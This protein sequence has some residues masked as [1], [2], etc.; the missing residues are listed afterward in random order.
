MVAGGADLTADLGPATFDLKLGLALALAGLLA[1]LRLIFQLVVAWL[2]ARISA[3]VQ[4]RLRRDVFGAFANASW[5]TQSEDREGQLQELMTSQI[6]QATNAVLSVANLLSGAAM[7]LVLLVSA[8]LLSVQ[9]A[10]AV[11]MSAVAMLFLLRPL[12]S[13]GRMAAERLSQASV[14]HAVGVNEAVQ[15]AE[16]AHVFG[17]AAEH[18]QRVG[19]LIETARGPFF[20]FQLSGRVSQSAYQGLIIL[21]IVG[22]LS[23]LYLTGRGNLPTLGAA[24]L[25]LVRAAT[26]GQQ[27]QASY[28]GLNQMQPYLDRL[29]SAVTR[30]RLSTPTEGSLSLPAIRTIAMREVAFSYRLDQPVLRIVSFEVAAGEA[31]GVVGPSGAGK[32]TLVQLLL[33]LRDPTSGTLLVNGEPAQLFARADWRRRVAYVGQEPR[34]FHGTVAD[35]IRYF[36]ALDDATVEQAARSA[37]IHDDIITMPEGYETVIG[38][39]TD[40]VSGGQRQRI[41]LARALAGKPDV[42]VL[43]EPTSA[44]DLSSE[45]AVAKSL[46]ELHGQVTLFIVAHRV[47]TLAGC[48]RVL[49]LADGMVAAFDTG[50]ELVRSNAFFRRAT[51]LSTKQA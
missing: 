28:H 36:R 27:A 14:D 6:D 44:L 50:A 46:A 8:F 40:A 37:H 17:T 31:I 19:S 38:Q 51:T 43:D 49:V 41:C 24:V 9:V 13:Y 16:E 48:D 5:S 25:I 23:G 3:D 2:P 35:N 45:A 33:R 11:L 18:R 10:A 26:Y 47:P 30:Y 22:G 39:R 1:V 7:F 42:L 34:L 12:N 21:L 32:S 15:L 29:D 20:R 4:A